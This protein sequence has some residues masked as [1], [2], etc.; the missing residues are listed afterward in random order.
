MKKVFGILILTLSVFNLFG[1]E[2][3]HCDATK[4]FWIIEEGKA[5][6]ALKIM[7]V[8]NSTDKPNMISTNDYALQYLV[9]D[10]ADFFEAGTKVSEM[11]ILVNYVSSEVSF[12]S[13]QF[14]TKLDA[15]MQKAPLSKEKEVI[16]WWYTMPESMNDEVAKQVFASVIFEEK[17]FAV[18]S[19]QF[20][21]QEFE[22]VRD[23]LVNVI[24]TLQRADKTAIKNICN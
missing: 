22:A 3:K 5:T 21:D 12:F 9:V 10:K 15:Q 7:G 13:D 6:Y 17:I 19:P 1:Q 18:A 23:F 4:S 24:S 16:I 2:L 14:Q 11:E 20:I 8:A